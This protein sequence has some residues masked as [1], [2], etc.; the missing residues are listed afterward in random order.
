MGADVPALKKTE[1]GLGYP[2]GMDAEEALRLISVAVPEGPGTWADFGAGDG[3]FTRALA[4]RLG[5]GA[6]IYAVDRDERALR[7]LQRGAKDIQAVVR[8]VRANLERPFELLGVG[9]G[10]LD[11][12]LLANTL[13]FIRDQSE[14]LAR[15]AGWLKPGGIAVVIEYDRRAPSR[16]VPHPIDADDLPALFEGAGLATPRIAARADSTFGGEI[17]VAMG[18]RR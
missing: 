17:Y 11:G 6:R 16:W 13:H 1:D 4:S 14:V 12:F 2:R 7:R 9:P 15:L 3:T 8:P 10:T 5:G 18:Q